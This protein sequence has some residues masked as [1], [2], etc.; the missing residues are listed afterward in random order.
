M[1]TLNEEG[2]PSLPFGRSSP[3]KLEKSDHPVMAGHVESE[4][5]GEG[6]FY[7]S[8][9]IGHRDDGRSE[10]RVFSHTRQYLSHPVPREGA[11]VAKSTTS[12]LPAAT[13]MCRLAIS[14]TDS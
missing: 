8:S 6:T 13:S 3:D 1:A 12:D 5:S 10:W 9:I 14:T 2:V 7:D 4:S 11:G